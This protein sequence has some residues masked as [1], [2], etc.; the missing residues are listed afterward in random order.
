MLSSWA[1]FAISMGY[2]AL[3]F[4]I[5]YLGDRRARLAGAPARKPWVYSLAL[6]VYCTSWT[7]YGAVG[8][9]ANSGWDFFPIYLGPMLV[10][11][12]GAPLL[13]RIVRISKRHNITSIADFVGARY[14]RH[15]P[16]AMLITGIAVIG[17]LP[18]VALQLKAVAFGFEVLSGA[19]ASEASFFLDSAIFIAALLAAFSILFGT[20]E[21]V[22][23]ENHHGMVLAIAFESVVK[24]VAF[25]GVGLYVMYGL[26]NGFADS[27]GY[28]LNLAQLR[29]PVSDATWRFGFIAQTILAGVAIFC[30]PRQFHVAVVES[31]ALADVRTA[32]WLFPA[33][34]ALISIFVVP[35]A[36]AGLEQ[37]GGS[38]VAPDTFVLELP[39]ANGH[40]WLALAAYLGGFSAATSMVIVE[41]IALSTMLC[42]EVVM[43]VL[44][45][46]GKLSHRRGQDVSR[47]IKTI[48]RTAIVL[49]VALAYVYYRLFTG[50]GTL[51]Q[52]GLLSFTA[53]AQFAPSIV[54]GVFWK[55]G[56]YQ[57][58]VAGLAI[59]W[60][61]W[62]YT[63]LL[64]QLISAFGPSE[65]VRDGIFGLAWLRPHELFGVSGLDPIT[66]GTFWSLSLN[67][68]AYV[69]VSLLAA[70]GL[71]ERLQA[72]RFL[73]Q[74]LEAQPA[75]QDLHST[76][77]T[78]GDVQELLDRFVG[79]DRARSVFADYASRTN[80]P[81]FQPNERAD[82]QLL[83]FAE[84]L[85]AGALGAASARLVMA[86]ML[87]G[88][89]MQL[90][91]VV[92]LLDETSQV[93]QFNRELLRAAL[94][95][96]S[97]GVSVVDAELR[98]VAWNQRYL[99]LF[100][101]PPGL[102]VIGRPIEDLMLYNASRG[103][104]GNGNL[105][106]A[107]R[108]RLDHMRA[109]HAYSHVREL[110][111]STVL[112]ISG[113]PMPGGGFV[114]SYSN[115]TAH[116]SAE[117][118]LLESNEMLE[119]RV[120]DRTR[121]L[122]LLNEA[123]AQAKADADRANYS[124]TR[125]LAAASHDL[126]QPI[127]AAR[128]FTSSI[129]RSN[130]PT[131]AQALLAQAGGALTT[132]EGLLAGLLDISRLDAGAEE[133]HLE[134]FELATLLGPLAA[135]FA[136]LAR[137]RGLT[138]RVARCGQVV[139]SDERL[140]RRVL[141]NFISNSV[142]YTR[143]GRVLVGCRRLPRAV[144]IE[145]WDSGPGIPPDKQREIF[146]EF[147]R[148]DVPGVTGDRGLGLG[149]AI[150]ERIARVLQCPLSLRSWTGHGSVFA[151]TVPLGDRAAISPPPT[152]GATQG[153]DRI[154]GSI[155]MCLE[156][157]PAVLSGIH[158]LLSE[159][160]C[161]VLAVRDRDSAMACLRDAS[162][163][164]HLL[165]VDYHLDGGVSGIWV[166][167]E[168]QSLWGREV[169]SIIIT[170]DHTQ[171]AKR[172]AGAQ[173]Y[174][175]LPKPIKPAALRALMNRMMA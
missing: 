86:S 129:D 74:A 157:E 119:F 13:A 43:P 82:T 51:A 81:A 63:L 48:R 155:V 130:V 132:A 100:G 3:L 19:P 114:T 107:V 76:S 149:L 26:R 173:G 133:T 50:P 148:L 65:L 139:Y 137:E 71:R 78:V 16:I 69:G 20:R 46:S 150:A 159:W 106:D 93:I 166:A 136:V 42:N 169:P 38:Q 52:I 34:L 90:E 72:V 127:T 1:L 175:V 126:A 122:T 61:L 162:E 44:L 18:Y 125:F 163:V 80:R 102:V 112:E 10:F 5:A 40:G 168:L 54:G 88:R 121:E 131:P 87:R 21:V 14:G 134:H 144:R 30:L 75:R 156:N 7:F 60:V 140:L 142:R 95:H 98:L 8:R 124:K 115:V 152:L 96:L 110:P 9:A 27:Y 105:E 104:L 41:T 56:R 171:D 118:A 158:A 25:L 108:R 103:L 165:L 147:R 172:A 66:H 59:G 57:G 28:A 36:A 164:P 67:L 35:I 2:V 15:Q 146:E 111:D 160:G 101:Y 22:S 113:N 143:K 83:R 154:A 141:Q 77:A 32:R 58:V 33:Y 4:A 79:Q 12:F 170:A 37:F 70:P 68:L 117:R 89:N 94:E 85:L 167:G 109:G 6:G 135:E 62:A 11:V 91:E 23:S 24:L 53:V 64:P 49:I 92:R 153:P 145:V 29:E 174:Q 31:A 116:K 161:R 151:I 123:L 39:L 97:Q 47:L 84:H 128:L 45:R 99:K 120:A 17:V 55:R 138:L 73:D